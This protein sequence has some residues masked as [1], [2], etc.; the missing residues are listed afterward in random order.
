[1]LPKVNSLREKKVTTP[2]GIEATLIPWSNKTI[3][4][5]DE[6]LNE[7]KK[8][9]EENEGEKLFSDYK[10]EQDILIHDILVTPFANI[11]DD[12]ELTYFD[13]NVLFVELYKLSK[14]GIIE[15]IYTCDKCKHKSTHNF[16]L[17]N[18]ENY[19]YHSID[20]T[21]IE[22]KDF[23]FYIK[24]YSDFDVSFKPGAH[25][26]NE[27]QSMFFMLSYIEKIEILPKV[28]GEESMIYDMSDTPLIEFNKWIEDELD[29][30]TWNILYKKLKDQLPHLEFKYKYYCTACDAKEDE[31]TYFPTLPDFSLGLL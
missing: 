30:A 10:L 31:Y 22:A 19:L 4:K 21:P 6:A 13:K 8:K 5:Y 1:M 14:G 17:N 27:E 25:K 23:K 3:L 7:L 16:D 28:E 15:T 26:A 9:Y 29:V 24:E 11:E 20:I 18:K 2:S 12:K